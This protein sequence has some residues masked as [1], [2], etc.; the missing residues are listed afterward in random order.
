MCTV[1]VKITVY[2]RHT[3]NHTADR[4]VKMTQ[5]IPQSNVKLSPM[6]CTGNDID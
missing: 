2:V 5:Y 4:C 3:R 1:N 6:Q